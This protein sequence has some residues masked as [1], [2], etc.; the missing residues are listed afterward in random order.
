ME[1]KGSALAPP[2][3]QGEYHQVSSKGD[4]L[5]YKYIT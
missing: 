3:S 5:I 1:N 4:L 2:N